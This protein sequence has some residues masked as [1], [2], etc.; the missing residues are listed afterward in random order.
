MLC[1]CCVF[2][3]K[4]NYR[5]QQDKTFREMNKISIYRFL[6]DKDD[7]EQCRKSVRHTSL[8]VTNNTVICQ[9][10]WHS[11]F[12]TIEI[13]E[14]MLSRIP[15]SV[16]SGVPKDSLAHLDIQM[17]KFGAHFWWIIS[18]TNTLCCSRR[19]F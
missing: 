8:N 2:A 15:P 4:A 10:Y 11:D 6:K 16:R 7:R 3:C 19:Y 5:N 12:E 9:L 13:H 17:V 18:N 1:N 14:K